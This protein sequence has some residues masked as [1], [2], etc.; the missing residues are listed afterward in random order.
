MRILVIDDNVEWCVLLQKMLQKKGHS[1][2]VMHTGFGAVNRIRGLDDAPQPDAVVLD[3]AMPGLSGASILTLV[4]Q[5]DDA[6]DLP[7]VLCTS[8]PLD[9]LSD[10]PELPSLTT[11]AKGRLGAVVSAIERV[12]ASTTSTTA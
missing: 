4:A 7:I 2:E 8:A 9:E 11:M 1:V 5:H 10:V 3:Y 6:R 12:A